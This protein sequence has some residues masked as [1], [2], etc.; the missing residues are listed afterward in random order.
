MAD[1]RSRL[2]ALIADIKHA[3]AAPAVE[4]LEE[5][6]RRRKDLDAELRATQLS[7]RERQELGREA[8]LVRTLLADAIDRTRIAAEVARKTAERER[9]AAQHPTIL[10]PVLASTSALARHSAGNAFAAAFDRSDDGYD[11]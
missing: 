5:F 11:R 4:V 10:D 6:A 7:V 1:L 2:Q 9:H 3:P 8:E